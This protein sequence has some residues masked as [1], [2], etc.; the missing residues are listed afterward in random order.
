MRAT[1]D[2]GKAEDTIL[3]CRSGGRVDTHGAVFIFHAIMGLTLA[4]THI[5]VAAQLYNR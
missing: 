5:T 1:F 3:G 2:A 4:R